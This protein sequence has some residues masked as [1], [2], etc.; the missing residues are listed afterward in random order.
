MV[1]PGGRSIA[2]AAATCLIALDPCTADEERAEPSR[3]ELFETATV[4]ARPIEDRTAAVEVLD[5][6]AIE[7]LGV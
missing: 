2:W 1:R 5:R 6:N 7:S 4:I 3:L